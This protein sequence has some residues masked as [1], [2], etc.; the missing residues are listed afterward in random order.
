MRSKYS[1][2]THVANSFHMIFALGQVKAATTSVVKKANG[3]TVQ[4]T[5]APCQSIKNTS[6]QQHQNNELSNWQNANNHKR[7]SGSYVQACN[8]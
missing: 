3:P 7:N 8:H 1:K 6:M 2:G 4:K 5:K